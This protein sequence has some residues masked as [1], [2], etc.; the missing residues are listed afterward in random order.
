VGTHL[1]SALEILHLLVFE[2]EEMQWK[3]I[4][5]EKGRIDEGEVME[6]V[7]NFELMMEEGKTFM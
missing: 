3:G 5:E 4:F 2:H 1:I 7:T 6:F